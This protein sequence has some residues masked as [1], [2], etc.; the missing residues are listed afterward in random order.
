MA[1]RKFEPV[2]GDMLFSDPSKAMGCKPIG[3]VVGVQGDEV[4]VRVRSGSLEQHIILKSE[5]R[6]I[7]RKD[8]MWVLGFPSTE[9]GRVNAPSYW[10]R[11]NY[12]KKIAGVFERAGHYQNSMNIHWERDA[13]GSWAVIRVKIDPTDA[14]EIVI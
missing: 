13:K 5:A 14:Q 12:L 10:L 2:K 11:G 8:R 9:F 4:A 6:V 7:E 3:M 1:R